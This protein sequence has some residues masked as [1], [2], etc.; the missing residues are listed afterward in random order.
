MTEIVNLT[1]HDVVVIDEQG[2]AIKR[3]PASGM[4]ARLNCA[5]QHHVDTI[6]ENVP[7]YTAQHFE[8]VVWPDSMPNDIQGVIVSM[9]FGQRCAEME[10]ER[11]GQ[12][13]FNVYGPDTSVEAVVRHPETGQIVGTKR[14]V[15][16]V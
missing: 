10:A 14:L 3:F 13:G 9:P 12:F 1:P 7:V 5:P 6:C 2:F 11:P 8:D 16:Y 4:T 15:Q